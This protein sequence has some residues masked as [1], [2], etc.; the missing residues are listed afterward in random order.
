LEAK[1]NI[2]QAIPSEQAYPV[3]W[4]AVFPFLQKKPL[5][6]GEGGTRTA[7]KNI[8]GLI[9]RQKEKFSVCSLKHC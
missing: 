7:L 4:Q 1:Q 3:P 9:M 8:L 2:I 6:N 5:K